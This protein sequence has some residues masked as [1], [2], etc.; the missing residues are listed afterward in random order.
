MKKPTAF[1]G[2][3]L[4]YKTAVEPPRLGVLMPPTFAPLLRKDYPEIEQVVRFQPQEY[5]VSYGATQFYEDRFFWVDAGVFE[6]F[7]WPLVQGDP[8]TALKDP[9]S[10]VLTE[11]TAKKYF[12][13]QN[14]LGE[15]ITLGDS[16]AFTVTGVVQDP[17]QNAHF[18]FDMLGA[19][20]TVE[21]LNPKLME[22]WFAFSYFTYVLVSAQADPA[23]LSAQIETLSANYIGD[24]ERDFRFTMRLSLQPL[25]DIHLYSNFERE[26]EPNGNLAYVYIFSAIAFFMLLIA[27]VNF[28]NLATARS[29]RRAKE[30][31]IRKVLGAHRRLLFK[32][33]LGESILLSVI[34]LLL[35]V[36]LVELFLPTFN[37]LSGKPAGGWLPEQ[38]RFLVGPRGH[39]PVCRGARR[40][41]SSGYPFRFSSST[42]AE[43]AVCREGRETRPLTRGPG[44]VSVHRLHRPAGGDGYGLQ[45][46]DTHATK[47]TGV[48]PRADG[49][50]ASSRQ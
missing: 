18:R 3:W 5:L 47:S 27:C 28:M 26:I 8:L 23:A 2:S 38:C 40:K 9:Y 14:P 36:A 19:F 50:R 4:N 7:T 16:T 33:F 17:P 10:V 45:P 34:A 11:S 41:L 44:R 12:G 46:D 13:V 24:W 21:Q 42:C 6:V 43:G 32:Q 20:S 37:A 1:T 30:V 31:G 29:I 39:R 49:G 22:E 25:T 15:V 35:A 48:R